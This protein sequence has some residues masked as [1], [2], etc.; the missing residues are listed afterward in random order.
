MRD[1]SQKYRSYGLAIK[2]EEDGYNFYKK[3]AEEAKNKLVRE[4]F[5]SFADDELKHKQIIVDFYNSLEKNETTEV[6]EK[7]G[8]CSSIELARTIFERADEKIGESVK[9][10]SDLIEPYKM[11]SEFEDEG[12]NFYKRLHESTISE[13][14][15]ELYGALMHM[16]EKHKEVL[17]NMIEYLRDPGDWF[18]QQERWTIEG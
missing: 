16:E 4:T 15:K 5:K 12:I 18:F 11:A 1:I 9:A 6:R 14:E 3:G 13:K 10:D 8:A 2:T 7:L 17:D